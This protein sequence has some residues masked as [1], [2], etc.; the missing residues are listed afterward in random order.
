MLSVIHSSSE[1]PL[2]TPRPL[3]RN[4]SLRFPVVPT[5]SGSESATDLRSPGFSK[6]P[7]SSRLHYRAVSGQNSLLSNAALRRP[8]VTPLIIGNERNRS[9]SESIL[10]ATQNTRTKRMGM[11][12]RKNPDPRTLDET[13]AQ[14]NSFHMRGLSHASVLRDKSVNGIINRAEHSPGFGSLVEAERQRGAFIHRLS[15]LPEHKRE[16]GAP[17]IIIN[18]AKG[19]LYSLHQIHPHTSSL[20]NVIRENSSKRSS[21]GRVYYN[22]STHLD[23]LDKAL[24][25][26]DSNEND[27]GGIRDRIIKNVQNLCRACIVAYQQVATLL[28]HNVSQ[29]VSE[30]EPKYIRTLLLLMYGSLVEARNS[31]LTLG[32][33]LNTKTRRSKRSAVPVIQEE[34]SQGSAPSATPT[35]DRPFPARRLQSEAT[36]HN[37]HTNPHINSTPNA[38]SA[39]PLYINGR[40]RSNSRTNTLTTSTSSSVANTP[41]SG[42]S[43][44]IP[45]TSQ[46]LPG[47]HTK[48]APGFLEVD[49]DAL[50]ERIYLD[51]IESVENGLRALPQVSLQFSKLLEIA[52]SKYSDKEKQ[53]FYIRLINRSRYCLDNCEAL[54]IRMSTIKLKEPEVR[55]SMDFWKLFTRYAISFVKLADVAKE[56]RRLRLVPIDIGR[57]LQPVHRAVKVA[58][59]DLKNSPWSYVLH[60]S[61]PTQPV[62]RHT[63]WQTNEQPNGFINSQRIANTHR[64]TRDGSGSGSGSSPYLTSVPAT[65]LSAA[66]GPA[67]QATVPNTP[68]HSASLDRSFQGDVFQRA[69]S[70]LSMQ[71]TILHRR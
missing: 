36:I 21:L 33:D 61:S 53:D 18:G 27:S 4:P 41:R 9:N 2:D 24:H 34:Y 29:L 37:I 69:E 38:Q 57:I 51:F 20:I 1:S 40:S 6:A 70:L 52:R 23:Q 12:T 8:G 32:I 7:V 25:Y 68:I 64:R 44:L 31:C 19:L 22:A 71:N 65:P 16:S 17:N 50:F 5:N 39:V 42:E 59:K 60:N 54:K 48:S 43:F 55:N 45:R 15:S 66:L 63:Q 11:V 47:S 10:Q 58:I 49:H 30:G 3:K 13:R 67:A 28:L 26:F 46:V 62:I 56:A 14:R 35:K